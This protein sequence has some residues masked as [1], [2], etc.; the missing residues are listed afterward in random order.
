M[1][2]IDPVRARQIAEDY[3]QAAVTPA[4]AVMLS[5]ARKLTLTPSEVGPEDIE[6][7]RNAGWDDRAISDITHIAAYFNFI[8]R[9]A[10]GIGVDLEPEM[11]PR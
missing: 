6:A 7:L 5:H 11:A 3:T 10:E 9:V 8:N 4:E 2:G 1:E